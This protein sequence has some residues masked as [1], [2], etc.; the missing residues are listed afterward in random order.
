[1]KMQDTRAGETSEV[2]IGET[3]QHISP[4]TFVEIVDCLI[5]ILPLPLKIRPLLININ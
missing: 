3:V 1:M 2:V 4:I 5:S